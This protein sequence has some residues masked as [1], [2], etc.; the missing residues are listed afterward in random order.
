MPKP[1]DHQIRFVAHLDD[2]KDRDDRGA[3]AALRRGLGKPPGTAPEMFRYVVPF[4]SHLPVRDQ[5]P[6]F[7]V[8]ALF[9]SHPEA[10]SEGNMGDTMHRVAMS[11]GDAESTERRFVA[12]LNAH[13]DDLP[14]HLRHAIGLAAGAQVPVNYAQ[15]IRDL[16]SWDDERRIVQRQWAASF[17]KREAR[18]QEEGPTPDDAAVANETAG[19]AD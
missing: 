12:L 18:Q 2:L 11:R 13:G 10:T 3:L 8:A 16:N 4:V 14:G 17:W 1:T 6:F 15:L 7:L 5:D 9:A 19:T